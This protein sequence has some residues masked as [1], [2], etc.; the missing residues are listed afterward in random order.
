[1]NKAIIAA[2]K[3]SNVIEL[4]S[5]PDKR[6]KN[7]IHHIIAALSTGGSKPTNKTKI[8]INNATIN[9]LKKYGK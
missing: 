2:D 7:H 4:F 1:L 6:T 5:L 3:I 8:I 9:G